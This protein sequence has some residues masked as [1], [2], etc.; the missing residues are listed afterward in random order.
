MTA[1]A[2]PPSAPG[3]SYCGQEV[4]RNDI[5]RFLTC[6]FA[7]ADRRE[8]LFALYAFHLEIAKTADVVTEPLLGRIRLQWWREGIAAAGE[9]RP[10]RHGVLD[11]LAAAMARHGLTPVRFEALIEAREAD[12]EGE[13]PDTLEALIAY[14]EATAVPLMHLALAILGVHGDQ[15]QAAGRHVAIA[16]ALT[17]LLR[18]VAV[19]L[20]R[21]RLRLPSQLVAE[22]GVDP[23]RLFD[24]GRVA[25]LEPVVRVVADEAVRH[26]SAARVLRRGVPRSGHAALMLA[27]L[28]D[29]SLAVLRREGYDVAAPRF[30]MPHPFRH[31]HLARHALLGRY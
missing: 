28:A 10:P 7:P 8:D 3:L 11:P 5:D 31:L 6:L 26:L 16:W 30:L 17:G 18:G 2:P 4:R 21:H 29:T 19:D 9:G 27:T 25:G 24:S 20:R 23:G 13:G 15:A 22:H 14:T 12:L 1:T